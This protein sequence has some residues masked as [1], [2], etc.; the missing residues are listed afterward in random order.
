MALLTA[1]SN[2]LRAWDFLSII[3]SWTV[4][5]SE[6][7]SV[8][9][10]LLALGF[11]FILG[12]L[13][14]VF[15][16]AIEKSRPSRRHHRFPREMTSEEQA[17]HT[18]DWTIWVVLLIG[19][20]KF[21]KRREQSEALPISSSS[22]VISRANQWSLWHRE[23]SADDVWEAWWIVML[24]IRCC[25]G[26]ERTLSWSPPG[27]HLIHLFVGEQQTERHVFTSLCFLTACSYFLSCVWTALS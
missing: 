15:I 9:P 26:R 16:L 13:D 8:L 5:F 12:L 19:W 18:D 21:P 14:L 20:S 25:G 1:N 17:L 23:I 2:G 24:I 3:W 11:Y 27:S 6:T 10:Y 22:D 7:Q 4:A